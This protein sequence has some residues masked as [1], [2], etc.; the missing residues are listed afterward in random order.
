MKQAA[1]K[2]TVM[3]DTLQIKEESLKKKEEFTTR[4]VDEVEKLKKK[5][6]AANNKIQYELKS[7]ITGNRAEQITRSYLN[8]SFRC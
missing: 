3:A 1:S 7:Q 8:N 6:N 5:L 2:I 4:L